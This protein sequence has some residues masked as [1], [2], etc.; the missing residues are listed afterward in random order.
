MRMLPLLIGA[1]VAA[2]PFAAAAQDRLWNQADAYYGA[3][4]MAAARRQVMADAGDQRFAYLQIERLEARFAD[5]EAV[6]VLD[7]Q[8][9]YGGDLNK[10][11][12]KGEAEYGFEDDTAEAAEI[13]ALYS[14]AVTAYFDLQAGLRQDLAGG[15]KPTY[16]VFGVQGLAPYWFEIDAAGFISDSGDL[17][18]RLEAEY[19]LLLTQRLVLQPRVELEAAAQD[20]AA[21]DLGGGFTKAHAG[22]RLRYEIRRRFA[23]YLG[24]EWEGAL[25]ETRQRL[26]AAGEDPGGASVLVGLRAWF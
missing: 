18:A 25:G 19:D 13:Q 3:D 4:D 17:T 15:D 10:V 6:G 24:V 22:V 5:G 14:R 1:A 12:L 8:G 16:A 26:R 2:T 9:W 23:P 21:Q 20:V 11:W 7:A